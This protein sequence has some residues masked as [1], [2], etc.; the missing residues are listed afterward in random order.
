MVDEVKDLGEDNG[1]FSGLDLVVI[2]HA[3]LQGGREKGSEP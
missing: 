3:S 2:E 1:A